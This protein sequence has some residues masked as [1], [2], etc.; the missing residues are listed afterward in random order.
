MSGTIIADENVIAIR[1]P[2]DH[3]RLK[4]V[5]VK[6]FCLARTEGN[7]LDAGLG[8]VDQDHQRRF[9]VDVRATTTVADAYGGRT[10]RL[11][12]VSGVVIARGGG[13]VSKQNL[14]AIG[15]QYWKYGAIEPS[16]I[17]NFRRAV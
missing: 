14:A 10:I 4:T 15:R 11:A 13:Y 7:D 17:T 2:I 12:D 1:E 9:G 16:Q 5:P 8:I 6:F 3:G